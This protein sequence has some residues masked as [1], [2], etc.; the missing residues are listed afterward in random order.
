MKADSPTARDP[1]KLRAYLERVTSDLRAERRRVR[2]LEGI[3]R[4]PIA[5][6]GMGCRFP[7]GVV[8]AEHLWE[9]VSSNTDAISTFP[10]D[11][12]WN[13]DALYDPDPDHLGT[14]YTRHGGFLY[15]AGD[16]DAAFFGIGPREVLATDP[17]QRLLLETAWEALE[18]AGIDPAILRGSQTGV[19]TGV[20]YPDYA[21]ESHGSSTGLEGHR[22]AG[23]SNSVAS[24]R[25][26]Y[27]LGLEGPAVSLDTACSSS[28]VALHLACGALL[29]G[30]CSMAL[31]GGVTVL[32]TPDVYVGFSR[33]RGLAPDGRC[34]SFANAADGTALSE[35]VGLLVLERLS[36]A[37]R[38]GHEVLAVVRGSA[39]NQDGASNGLTAP[40]GPSQERVIAQALACAGVSAE[41]V[42]AVE[43]HGTGTVL[44]D[45]IEAQ[46][47]LAA[48]GAHHTDER[49]LWLGSVKSNIGHTQAA[50]GVA[51]VIKMV[52][53]MRH[54]VLP[55]TLHVDQPSS[56]V[57]W[58]AGGVSLLTEA[59]PWE[60][61]GRP[62]RAGVSSFGVSG[63]NA[64]VILEEAPAAGIC[65]GSGVGG[66]NVVDGVGVV[67]LGG[68]VGFVGGVVP[69]VLSGRGEGALRAQAGRL[70]EFLGE[71]GGSGG[72]VGFDPVDVGFSLA[73]R[74]RFESRAVVV[75]E[76]RE[77]LVG[78]L[79]AV[80]G[81]ESRRGVVI[82]SGS[83]SAGAVA[84]GGVVF[85]FPG[86]GSQWVGMAV[87]LLDGSPV[88]A[89]RLGE[90]ERA[91][92]EY[93]GWSVEGV[94]RGGE[95]VPGFD[96]VDVVQPVL[97]AVMVSLAGLW[98]WC[99]VRPAAVVGHSQGEIAAAV[100]AGG[101]SL[102]DGARVVA[103]RARALGE[104]AG[105]GG[106]VSVALGAEDVLERIA[107][108][109]E[110]VSLAA[111]NGPGS[112]VVSGDP[113]ALQELLAECEG[114]GVRARSIPVDYAAHSVQIEAIREV[115]LEG[116]AGIEPQAGMV[117]FYSSVTGGQLDTA[118]LD[119]EYWYRN[120][121]ETVRFEEATTALL[122]SGE[123]GF[124]EVSPHPVLS[125][126]VQETIDTLD[127]PGE[128]LVVGSLRRD[129]GGTERFLTSLAEV[130]VAGGNVDWPRV[131]AGRGGK[132]VSLPTYAFQRQRYWLTATG[133]SG[134]PASFGQAALAQL[135][136]VAALGNGS[137]LFVVE[138]PVVAVSPNPELPPFVVVDGGDGVLAGG[139]S[140]AGLRVERCATLAAAGEV[141]EGLGSAGGV[142]LVDCASYEPWRGE[143]EGAGGEC[144]GCVHRGLHR[145]VGLVQEWL[146]QERWAG[147]CLA[148]VTRGAVGV[149]PDEGLAGVVDAPVW[150]LLRAVQL[151]H[152]GRV[153]LVDV[154]GSEAS[155][156]ALPGVLG[157]GEPQVAL[158]DGV[159]HVPRLAEAAG[160]ADVDG[161][162]ALGRVLVTGGTGLL[163]GLV[164]RHLVARYDA[165]E[166][167]L[168]SRRGLDAPGARELVGEL[169]EQGASVSVLACD[170][171]DREQLRGV[172]ESAGELDAVVHA[173]GVLDDGVIDSL[174]VERLDRVLAAKADAAW[175]LHEL[176]ERMDLKAFV[177]FSSAAGV[178][179]SPGQGNYAAANA[180][181]DALAAYRR[182]GG[183]AAT[184]IGWGLWEQASGMTGDL[185]EAARARMARSGL[186]ALGVEE[187]LE[188]FDAA[189]AGEQPMVLATPI[190]RTTLRIWAGEE[191]LPVILSGLVRVP[192]WQVSGRRGL[193]V[194]RLA[195]AQEGDRLGVALEL[196]RGQ[197]AVVL[198]HSSPLAIAPERP[199][200]DLG[201]DSLGA[202]E[203]RNRLGVETGLRLPASLVFDYPTPNALASHLLELLSGARR[204]APRVGVVVRSEEP[205]AIVG[206][207]CR[208]P[209]GVCSPEGLW[210]LV[211]SE[212]DAISEF[213]VDRGWDVETVPDPDP[214]RFGSY[215]TRGGFVYD[216]G[217]FD[218]EFFGVSPREAL[219]MDPQQR[220]LLE[221]AWEALEHAGIDPHT[222]RGSP[223]GVFAGVIASGYGVGLYGLASDQLDGYRLTGITG[224]VV[225][226]RVSY[227]LG[228]QGPAMSVDTGCSS[229][230]VALHLACGALHAGECSMALVGGATV[231]S[232]PE[233]FIE[234]SRQRALA[235]DGRCKS[236]ADAADGTGFSEGVGLL[237]LER[238]SEAEQRGHRVLGL[239]RGSAVNQDGASNGLT[240]PNGPSQERVIAQAL[241]CAGV[242]AGD[243]DVVEGHGTGT[244]L[245]DPIEAQAL[246]AAY[247]QD[248]ARPL[249][250]GSVKSNIGHTQAAAGVA[251]VI[252][253]VMA[254]R[255]GVLP[256]TLHV[257]RPSSHV[258]WDAGAI[259]LLTETQPW[260]PNGHPRRAGVSSFGVSGTNAHVIL[261]EAP[262]GIG[263]GSEVGGV[264]VEGGV[265]DVGFV[266]GVVPW[267]LSGR[268]EGALRAQAGRLFEFLGEEGGS[269]GEV[270]FDPVDVG[271]SLAGRSRF[272]S[273]AVVV[274]EGREGLVGGLGAVV[275]GESRRGVVIGSGSGSAGAVAGGG[276][277]FVFP[278]QGSQWVGMAVELLDGSPVFAE[279]L[280]ECERALSEYVGWS[281]EGVLRG[282]EGVPGFDRVDV[283][284]PVLWAV[285]V[286]LAG[287]WEWCGVRPAAVVGHSQGEI[288]AAVVAGGL[289]LEDGARIVALRARA[290]AELAG[291][292][293]MVSVALGAEDVLERIARWGERVSLAAVNGPG[294][295]VVSGDP[296]ALQELLAECEGD[297]VRARSIPVDYAAHSV[298]IEA[299]REVLLEG[300]AGI[301]PQAGMVPFYSSVTG[302]QLDTA[303]LD[304]EYWYRNLRETVRFEEAT[305]ALLGSG[306][307]G[308]VE[309]SP[310][311]VL[312]VGVQETIDTLDDPGESLVVGSLRRDEGGTERFLT[313]LAEVWVAGGNVDWPRVFAGRGGK[314]VSLPTYA[315]QR[316]RYWLTA[317]GGSGDPASFGQA[318]LRHPLLG[319]AVALA[320]GDGWL[321]TG[322][323]SLE[324]H[325]W[326]AD[327]VVLGHVLLPG[328]ALLELALHAGGELDVPVVSELVLHT[329]VVIPEQG[330]LQLQLRVGA[331]DESGALP[332]SIHTRLE[333]SEGEPEGE[334]VLHA[335]GT[336]APQTAGD[337]TTTAPTEQ[338]T[339]GE[340]P[341][342]GAERLDLDG[343]YDRVADLGLEYGPTFQGLTAAWSDGEN[344]YAEVSLSEDHEQQA[345]SYVMHP[346]LLDS[347]LHAGVLLADRTAG[348]GEQGLRIPFSWEGVAVSVAGISLLRVCLSSRG[349]GAV[350]LVAVDH[351][352][353]VVASVE[354]V[355]VR[356]FGAAQLPEVAALGNGSSL[357]VVEWPVV[358]VSPNPE[359]PPFVVVDGGD[360]VLAGG[361]S[362]AG[363]RV[364]RCATLAAAGEVFEGL[365][366]AG[367]VVLVDCASYEPWR[368]EGEGAGG[369]CVG[370]VHRGLHRVVG[371]VQE[372]LSQ[373]RWAGECLAFVTRGAVG[374]RPDEGLAG[375]V[376]APVWGL[377]RAV[378]LEHPGRV[379]LVDV[380]GS[381]ASGA[382]LPGVLGSGE[383][384][385]A[386][387]D[388][389]L[390]VPR[391]A[392]AAGV[393]DVDGPVALGRVLVTGGTGLLGG[394]VAR[395]LVA[396]YDAR[397][398]VLVSRRGLDAPGARELVGELE[399]QGASV[400]VLACDVGDREQLRGV[401]ESAGELDAVVH[402]AGVLDD[403]VI[404]SLTVERLDRVLAAKAD[405]AWYL[406]ELTERMDLKAFVMFSGAAGVLGNPGQGNYAA[407]N[408]FLDAL[409]GYRR[410]A[411]LVATSIGWGLWEQASGMTGDLDEAARARMARSGL[412]ALG[413][414]E[415]LELFDA[416][417]AGEQPMVLATPIDRTTLRDLAQKGSLLPTLLTDLVGAPRRWAAQGGRRGL[418]VRRLAEAQE[419]DRL[420]VA[421]ELVRGQAAVVLGHSSPLAIAPERPFKDLGFDS[422]G[423]VELRNRL[424]V[425][426]GLRLPASLVFDYPTPNALAS[427]L[428]ELLSGARRSAPR[429]G[430]VVRSEE[431]VAIVG[432]GCR[433]PG[434][435]CS[436]E[437]LW[438]LVCSET[439]AISEFPVDRGWDVET[440]PDPDPGRFGS[441]TTRG[442]FVY[443]AGVFDAEFFGVSPREALAMDPQQRLLLEAAWEALEHAG[444]DPHTLRGSP[445]GVFAGVMYQDYGTKLGAIP[446]SV[447]RYLGTGVSGS[448]LSGRVAYTFG[449]E[450]PT[451]SVDT[452]CSSSLVALHLACGALRAGECSI[453]L[454]G[455]V[456]VLSTPTVFAEFSRQG[457]LARDGRCKSFADAADGT[458]FSEGAGLLL[459]ERLSDAERL[460]HGVLGLVRGS[461][462]NQDGASNGLTA[463]NGP[464]QERLIAQALACAG[465]S[466]GDVDVVEGH[467][468]G[469][470][471]GDPI[472]AQALLA[473]YGQDRA[474]PLWLGSV[475]SNIGHTQAAAGVAGV[476][477]MVMAM[478]HGVLPATLHVD[479]PSSHVDWGAGGVSL[480]T[481]AQPWEPNGRPRRAGVS[482]FGVSG[483]NA[484]VILEEA[485]AVE[486]V[487]DV[488][489]SAGFAGGVVPLVVS[490]RSV[491]ALRDLAGRLRARLEGDPELSVVD[492]GYSL[493]VGRAELECRAV[494]SGG[495]RAGVLRGLEAL[496]A[497]VDGVG[498][499]EGVVGGGRQA[500]LF[501]GQ[502]AQRVGM[503]R[504]LYGAFPVFA[505]AVDGLCG[506]FDGLLGCSLR[507]VLFAEEGSSEASLVD[508]TEFTQPCLFVLELA[509]CRLFESFGVRPDVVVGHS[510]GELVAG[511]VAGVFS[512]G[513]ACRLV[514]ARG[515]LMGALPAGGVMLAVGAGER[516]VLAGVDELGL[517]GRVSLAAV[518]GPGSV[519]VSGE[520]DGVERLGLLWGERGARTRL[521]NVS[522]AFHSH[523]MDGM[524]AEFEGVAGGVS[525]SLPRIPVV[526]NLTGEVAGEEIATAGYWVRQARETVRFADGVRALRRA[527]V[528]RMLELGPDGVLS[529]MARETLSETP[530]ESADGPVDSGERMVV[531]AALRRDRGESEV[532]LGALSELW[533]HGGAVEW[534]S[535]FAG[536]GARRV[537][538]PTYAFQRQRYWLSSTGGSGDP[539]SF[540]Q[541]A[542]RHPLLGA[543]VA[544]ADGDGWLFTGRLSLE[545]HPWLADHVVL[546]HVLLPGTA[547][548]ELALHAG[549]ELD[550]P[551]VSELVL[552][553][554]VVIPEQGALQLQVC[555]GEP[556]EHGARPVSIHTCPQA[557]LDADSG[558]AGE[559]TRHATGTLTPHSQTAGGDG[560]LI[561]RAAQ[562]TG[563]SWPPAGAER[564]DLD[565]FY[566][567]MGDLGLEYGPAFQGLT[568]AWRDGEDLYAEVSLGEDHEQQAGSFDI[569]PALLDSA[570]HASVL[571]AD[572]VAG[573][574]GGG[575]V[576]LPFALSG[577]EVVGSG[578]STLRV[579]LSVAGGDV[580]LLAADQGSGL[581]ACV[582]SLVAREVSLSSLAPDAVGPGLLGVEWS[583]VE[584]HGEAPFVGEVGVLG[585]PDGALAEDLTGAGCV[586]RAYGDLPSL[587]ESLA[588][589]VVMPRVVVVDL[590]EVSEGDCVGGTLEVLHGSTGGVLGLLRGWLAEERFAG[591]CLVLLSRS[592][593][594]ARAGEIVGGLGQSGVWGLVRSAQMEAPGRF[595]LVDVD[596]DG[597]NGE[598]GGV[599][600]LARALAAVLDG[601]PGIVVREGVVLVARVGGIGGELVAP[602]GGGWRLEAGGSG[603]LESLG[604]VQCEVAGGALGE[605]Q[606]RVG[607]RAG[608][609]N[610]RDVL[611]AL[612]MYPGV[613]R[614]GGEGAGV[615]L[616]V[617]PRVEGLGVGDRVMGLLSGLGPVA[618]SD[619][620]LLAGMPEGWSFAEAASVPVA[621]LTAYYG[622]VDLAGLRA[623]E[624]VL[625]H[626]ATGGVGMAAV[627]LARHLGA[628]V[629]VTASPGKWGALRS[630]RFEESHIASS[631]TS[632]FRERFLKVTGG[633][634]MDVVLNSL[635]GELVDASLG[636]L[637]PGGRL[638]EMGKTDVRDVEEVAACYPGVRYRAFDVSE[639][640]PERI[641]EMLRELGDLFA[642]GVLQPLPVRAWDV[643]RAREAFRFM[644]QARHTGKIVLSMPVVEEGLGRVLVTGGTGLLG[645]LV[646]RHLLACHGARELVL[647]SRRGLDAPGAGELVADLE[648]LGASV[649]VLACDVGDREQLRGVVESAGELDAVVHAA[650]VLD[651]G[652][653]DS[654]TVERLDRVLAAKADA[655]WY[656]HELT[657]DMDLKAFVLFSSAAGV[658]GSPGQGSYAAANA[659]LDA[660]AAH[661]R[662]AGLV[663]TSI[664]WGLW[665]RASGMTGDLDDAARAR[666]ARGGLRALGVEEGLELFDAALAGER[667]LVL[668]APVDRGVLRELAREGSLPVLLSGL[669]GASRRRSV[670][671]EQRGSF[672]RRLAG[673]AEGE[674]LGVVLEFVRSQT[675]VVLGHE[676]SAAVAPERSFKDLGFD[677]LGVV[678]LRNRLA[679]ESG[680][681]LPASL[682]FDYPTPNAL[683]SHLLAELTGSVPSSRRAREEAELTSAIASI[684]IDRLRA[685]GLLAALL[686]LARP[687]SVQSAGAAARGAEAIDAMDLDALVQTAM[688]GTEEIA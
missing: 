386:L 38:L 1:D 235:R 683:A 659:F 75:G 43:G 597:V 672:A 218:A 232:T 256:A 41:E 164:A 333:G 54:G 548:L 86:Q 623:G 395:H 674:R 35:G 608:G 292:G 595:A 622:L 639:A 454:A 408:A 73:G 476:I 530:E 546:G 528:T 361:L 682:V 522:H 283:V 614:V 645:G 350:S 564:L 602:T 507:G 296:G 412:G 536:C 17:Q 656:L 72:E 579:S 555:V 348:P 147:E 181:L 367:G 297:G 227:V 80:V 393:A 669:V 540:G 113:G 545:A 569:H 248:R 295:V 404:D 57:D 305:T 531:A 200:K 204:S 380:D 392:E 485:P 269:G 148:F 107:R 306:E 496:G 612:G 455:G 634:G 430:V 541:A 26:A 417:L 183:L 14:S 661:R 207:G 196:V 284:Q 95:G 554:P 593:V 344:L 458:G 178:L 629:F 481:E 578:A 585:S 123:R 21:S 92:S 167:V 686:A 492:V 425:E 472:E 46:A 293:G 568:A 64:H 228:L 385:V 610:F 96:R 552:H 55:A 506:E 668:A 357:F 526:S 217:V 319:A 87:E 279:R 262:A 517:S 210:N 117:P 157:S 651:D 289:S 575:V 416:A 490:A 115:L 542:L 154:D 215:T 332:L 3:E 377:L 185:D 171:G 366:S 351:A 91:L 321:F 436:P 250:L 315:F 384:Q 653:I 532:L 544:L 168:V 493:V 422:L 51:G 253:M 99:G 346:A 74:S 469:T 533:V 676:G 679:G 103:L 635:A 226:G 601:E 664:A 62:R 559:W 628:E 273:R 4:E 562:L 550:V 172:V 406:H 56:H 475:K 132:P 187:G 49:P 264:G 677:S 370:C 428:L 378:Q 324:S 93:V 463:P 426:T 437:G 462:V 684:P 515:R 156:A 201:F 654:L 641:G 616:E 445:T 427:H 390:H 287:L 150:G 508:R 268:G 192:A 8:S 105:K 59:Q 166:L 556:D 353:A 236:F 460:G 649:S 100:V 149:R 31:A 42:D 317:T 444:I 420:G 275:G 354:S 109:G 666:M 48:Y 36:D 246:L 238:L 447:A 675:A 277:V 551:V 440:V 449:F 432:I 122:G 537:A 94:L 77:G 102:E 213:P 18:H 591:A 254:M 13:V 170:V 68:G 45:P 23:A 20:M 429:V 557:T 310:H 127:D 642:A 309:V 461:A 421:L 288:A 22:L 230:L 205:V 10:T 375:V 347:A 245:G 685:T 304:G 83:G 678:E 403:G 342:P 138:W 652:V 658:V 419:G 662:G 291:K 483:T 636:L 438:N 372:W 580:S 60:P 81:G 448:V 153:M 208:Y 660:L 401:V 211:C 376:D 524:L 632:E 137:S 389:V 553:T 190:D 266:G 255:H 82:G 239:V 439:D 500:F 494:V 358:A 549:G 133:G 274:G 240:A 574:D 141:F 502:G 655:A 605:G 337:A 221:A 316:Q 415:G 627:Q 581:V 671:R 418:F 535:L 12:E 15:D 199:F 140:E 637:G 300:C 409:A 129:E 587:A 466:A 521:L 303:T 206:I 176:T 478:R 643:R 590:A 202:V 175:Y 505:E 646:A 124:V 58:G 482:S 52:M 371:L 501:T 50:A 120:L 503:G 323:L 84:G 626:A 212:T 391:L 491:G 547:L 98:E 468:T 182:A 670:Q 40:N 617:G 334:W 294:S 194:R 443:D 328:T 613:G 360:G 307:R 516:E 335:T 114:D 539:A 465:V 216:A 598:S 184:S 7:G 189:L 260:E 125:V 85:V 558:F 577:V 118:T 336:L 615:V 261:E 259:S 534:P 457:G 495:E 231:L 456:T 2:E 69:W 633:A 543:A 169:E 640:S 663:A 487:V 467:G 29:G 165:R 32:G 576:R 410:A 222:L 479:R 331:A 648:G 128:S 588:E 477:K 599:G 267:V 78:G 352:G 6:I 339:G 110:R 345:N 79:G 381:E 584:G 405:A 263:G 399:E 330:G 47:L 311:P 512:V 278:G 583:S 144:V 90:C 28:L 489:A 193:F 180:F 314:P 609:V 298:Q 382:A 459:L 24:G 665:E 327:H 341:P 276:V 667:A 594:A 249:W 251:G 509:L 179:G 529:A 119:G 644:S 70:F 53:A 188:L 220:L 630:L 514:A 453:A 290:L 286:S 308:F 322:R 374:V 442:G 111:V 607:L 513:D 565:G 243:V 34:K 647:V 282:G 423:A 396:R 611:I 638:V 586:V 621:F 225:S 234:F 589:G 619:R 313:S 510:V 349:A 97:W 566:D 247:G 446:D 433:Y 312:S 25:I 244:V 650:G 280:G 63:T 104:L 233:V 130:W 606:V 76:G 400:S 387:R 498:V 450:G 618:V 356:E 596:G 338:L 270:G 488:P 407:A 369:E 572:R 11:R 398:L 209:G 362:E 394:L 451:V 139:L 388:G 198:G 108:W 186:G 155:G 146:S 519:V 326:L 37:E 518:N 258:D 257:D 604:L 160:V 65:G 681:Q 195:E 112:V 152:P 464:S 88:F 285:M 563:P 397:E 151:E 158:R 223:T 570:L 219:A 134:D 9:L 241:A 66:E 625:V 302:G 497:G 33:Q 71:E 373:E 424:G 135:P 538:L 320:D 474:R 573:G 561:G 631:R 413:V 136:E 191:L 281:V 355:S 486:A 452:A 441:Y 582:G 620:R 214:G 484:H 511:C 163:G 252:K 504:E 197:A 161:P 237:V 480:L 383:P 174:T 126:G 603:S 470:V 435:V 106:M 19:F 560:A 411:G 687:E 402:A 89:E 173:A 121:R 414:E 162:V 592:A 520:R 142:V 571:L 27:T 145:V 473:A 688:Q 131:F 364:E 525:F 272:E 340:W 5:I 673:V 271:F 30:E 329:P 680:L 365:G 527:G 523:L 567:R 44:G 600:G 471:L 318:A 265:G 431:P 101:L 379:M 242:S 177:M 301:E 61:N 203:L 359:L 39:V 143:G 499:V 434:G 16:F 624:R 299:I 325:P 229:S 224:S 363:L 159:L 343:F 368:G 657:A 116:C 67:E